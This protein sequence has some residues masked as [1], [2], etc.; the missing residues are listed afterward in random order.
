[1]PNPTV[2]PAELSFAGIGKETTNGT[3]VAP[4]RYFPYTKFDWQDDNGLLIDDA[5]YGSMTSENGAVAGKR[6]A[7]GDIGGYFLPDYA[8]DLL[9]NIFGGYAVG[10]PVSSVYPHTFS[11]LNSGDGQPPAHTFVDRQG[12]TATVGARAYAYGCLSELTFSGNATGLC[13]MEAKATAYGSAPAASAPTNTATTETVIPAWR[14]TVT[15][16]GSAA[17]VREWSIT[18]ARTL[19]PDQLADGTQNPYSIAR[20]D[21][22]CS[23]KL[24]FA[25]RNEQPLLDFIAATQ[26]AVVIIIDNGGATTAVRKLTLTATKAV[27]DSEQMV[28]E[29]PIGYEMSFKGIANTTDVGSSAGR[30]V[31]TA[32]LQNAITTY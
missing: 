24:T 1:M 6:I 2:F 19:K 15:V 7:T 10:A 20:A 25:A 29:T 26:Q 14:S 28:R 9:Y 16:A 17:P 11:L 30:G 4:V 3:A 32:L 22:T 27:Y 18:F 12:I 13:T 23:G 21:L 5:M 31:A 8:G